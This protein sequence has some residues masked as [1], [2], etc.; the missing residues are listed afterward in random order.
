M[1]QKYC[2]RLYTL[3]CCLSLQRR[4]SEYCLFVAKFKQLTATPFPNFMSYLP[5]ERVSA[6]WR[7]ARLLCTFAR[8]ATFALVLYLAEPL[9]VP[10]LNEINT[11]QYEFG[12]KR[13]LPANAFAFVA[14]ESV[15]L[16]VRCF[17]MSNIAVYQTRCKDNMYKVTNNHFCLFF[18]N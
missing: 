4:R 1:R 10:V 6:H 7:F 11:L 15:T 5:T 9:S 16:A 2:V 18:I 17:N 3:F 8:T 13:K 14:C 12:N